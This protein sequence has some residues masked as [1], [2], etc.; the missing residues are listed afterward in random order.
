M[1]TSDSLQV[2]SVISLVLSVLFS[3]YSY[4]DVQNKPFSVHIMHSPTN[5][6]QQNSDQIKLEG[7]N[8]L[9][10]KPEASVGIDEVISK[11]EQKKINA[12]KI[13]NTRY[14]IQIYYKDNQVNIARAIYKAVVDAG[15]QASITNTNLNEIL[16]QTGSQ[17]NGTIYI[18][19]RNNN[20]FKK[21]EAEKIINEAIKRNFFKSLYIYEDQDEW[22]FST[23][24]VQIYLF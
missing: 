15:Y 10:K 9:T 24:D 17:K 22:V 20:I 21:E 3:V 8:A 2:L 18:A 5:S 12:E 23:G 7:V 4:Y 11:I 6:Q 1:K 13:Q 14:V 19:R 16:K